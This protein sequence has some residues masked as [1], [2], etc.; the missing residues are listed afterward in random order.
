[1]TS[2]LTSRE[3]LQLK[4]VFSQYPQITKVWL[5]GSRSRGLFRDNSDIDLAY[6]AVSFS[7]DEELGLRSQLSAL[8]IPYKIDLVHLN[9]LEEVAFRQKI[10]EEKK[11]L[12]NAPRF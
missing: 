9:T 2:G 12:Y 5:F 1:M 7:F 4:G 10:E 8:P 11:D 6:E 3:I